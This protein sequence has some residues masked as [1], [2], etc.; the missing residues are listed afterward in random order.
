MS[1]LTDHKWWHRFFMVRIVD[2]GIVTNPAPMMQKPRP[3]YLAYG[4]RDKC[5]KCGTEIEVIL[6]YPLQEEE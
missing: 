3:D 5:T 6:H 1:E 2:F 4:H